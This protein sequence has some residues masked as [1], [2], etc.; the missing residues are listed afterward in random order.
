MLVVFLG[1]LKFVGEFDTDLVAR[2]LNM[3]IREQSLTRFSCFASVV[4]LAMLLLFFL[5]CFGRFSCHASTV[6][7][8]LLRDVCFCN[9]DA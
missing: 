6:F 5:L 1:T 9:D 4:F 7:L 3:D 8:A 2:H